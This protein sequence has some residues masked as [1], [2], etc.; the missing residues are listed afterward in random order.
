MQLVYRKPSG[1]RFLDHTGKQY[2]RLTVIEF[3][4]FAGKYSV[5]RCRCACGREKNVRANALRFG[6]T[7]SCGCRHRKINA[8]HPL[9]HTWR[10]MLQR[11]L[12]PN[13]AAYKN[14]GGRG[15]SVCD[16]WVNSFENFLADMG[17]RPSQQMTIDRI[18]ND[19]NYE[20]GNVRWATQ[21]EQTHNQR[22]TRHITFNG[23]TKI[24]SE[25]ASELGISRERLRQR[26]CKMPVN[27][28]LSFVAHAKSPAEERRI[29]KQVQKR[30]L[31]WKT[32]LVR[33]VEIML[34]E[35]FEES[36]KTMAPSILVGGQGLSH[37]ERKIRRQIMANEVYAGASEASVAAKY[38]V[39]ILTV[40]NALKEF[41]SSFARTPK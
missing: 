13:N 31:K 20:P 7:L 36:R 12:N 30:E 18:D 17:E 16:R 10:S 28:A 41:P 14:Y 37:R 27:E 23:Q 8:R 33:E 19:G 21:K 9:V 11:C 4:G 22:R 1:P 2:G 3:A 29:K 25:W 5:W 39:G 35:P 40:R 34:R 32:K 6:H 38:L 26:L 24:M 15:I